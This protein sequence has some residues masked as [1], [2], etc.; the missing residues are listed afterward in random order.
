MR[1]SMCLSLPEENKFNIIF[2]KIYRLLI[3]TRIAEFP[4]LH[5][6]FTF[7]LEMR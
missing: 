6:R 1:K 3:I 5:N 4:K 7:R 2:K